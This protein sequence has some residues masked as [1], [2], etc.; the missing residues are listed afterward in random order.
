[1]PMDCPVTCPPRSL[2]SWIPPRP[3]P[4]AAYGHCI[5]YPPLLSIRPRARCSPRRRF[6]CFTLRPVVLDTSPAAAHP[7]LY[8]CPPAPTPHPVPSPAVNSCCVLRV[9]RAPRG[10]P[11]S[12]TACLLESCLALSFV[13]VARA[14]RPVAPYPPPVF[15]FSP[16][17]E[18]LLSECSVSTSTLVLSPPFFLFHFVIANS[19]YP[20]PP[21]LP[22]F[23][24]PGAS[25]QAAGRARGRCRRCAL[26]LVVRTPQVSAVRSGRGIQVLC[27][28]RCLVHAL[29]WTRSDSDCSLVLV[30]ASSTC[31]IGSTCRCLASCT[32]YKRIHGRLDLPLVCARFRVRSACPVA[33]RVRGG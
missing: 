20:P 28:Y 1:M 26:P 22:R 21:P 32:T 27:C 10:L 7:P 33:R 31:C 6:L 3:N 24:L 18:N 29:S 16:S 17:R 23:G 15:P 13:T 5:S 9:H 19:L 11:R 14:R 4:I 25:L 12:R 30:V 8:H 2:A